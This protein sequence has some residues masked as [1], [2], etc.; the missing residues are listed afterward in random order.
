VVARLIAAE[1]WREGDPYILIVTDAGYDIT[2][3]A[4][5]LDD[6]PVELL[7]RIRSDRVLRGPEPPRLATAPGWTVPQICTP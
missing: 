6:L 2:R 5:V 3:Q 1:H 7:G 4:F